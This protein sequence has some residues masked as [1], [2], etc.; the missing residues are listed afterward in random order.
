MSDFGQR[1]TLTYLVS[2]ENYQYF[3]LRALKVW[4]EAFAN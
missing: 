3:G 1:R 2:V 4:E